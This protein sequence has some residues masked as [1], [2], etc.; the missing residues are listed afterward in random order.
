MKKNWSKIYFMFIVGTIFLGLLVAAVYGLSNSM[1]YHEEQNSKKCSTIDAQYILEG[2]QRYCE[3]EARRLYSVPGG[4][5]EPSFGWVLSILV[6]LFFV[7]WSY[8]SVWEELEV[9]DIGLDIDLEA[10]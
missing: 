7:G 6:L 1:K 4:Y 3:D 8:F 2:E 5:T 10:K 9:K